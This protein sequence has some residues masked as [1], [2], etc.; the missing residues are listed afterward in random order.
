MDKQKAIEIL[1][2]KIDEWGHQP[3]SDGYEYEKSFIELMQGLNQELF[4]LSVGDLPQ[5]RNKKKAYK[6]NLVT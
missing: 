4:Q 6:P 3:K 1:S 2:K 5:D